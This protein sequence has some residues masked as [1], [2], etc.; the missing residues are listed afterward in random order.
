[1]LDR[2]PKNQ[3]AKLV[4]QVSKIPTYS[5]TSIVLLR[6]HYPAN[7]RGRIPYGEDRVIWKSQ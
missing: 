7:S 2:L 4:R 1:M 6:Y 3:V 5:K